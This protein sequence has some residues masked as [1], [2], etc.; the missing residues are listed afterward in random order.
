[1]Q[2][3]ALGISYSH[4]KMR[5]FTPTTEGTRLKAD[6]EGWKNE[7]TR[8]QK[9]KRK[10]WARPMHDA[11]KAMLAQWVFTIMTNIRLIIV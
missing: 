4:A 9:G 5:P 11:D 1:M 10:V 6:A 3:T 8:G 7:R 2:L